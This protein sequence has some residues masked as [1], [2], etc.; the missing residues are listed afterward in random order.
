MTKFKNKK[1]A[2][3]K[4]MGMCSCSQLRWQ[5]RVK[6]CC[7]KMSFYHYSS[8]KMES[9]FGALLVAADSSSLCL[10]NI[11]LSFCVFFI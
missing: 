4:E 3:A 9:N 5:L 7:S 11:Q 8:Q 1:N 10:Q 2:C 6:F